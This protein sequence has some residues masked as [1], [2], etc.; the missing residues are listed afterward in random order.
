MG[1]LGTEKQ[2]R[3]SWENTCDPT[4]KKNTENV[5]IKKKEAFMN[6]RKGG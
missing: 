2:S 1:I 5:G 6:M 4:M 3:L